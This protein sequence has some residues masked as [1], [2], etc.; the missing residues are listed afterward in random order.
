MLRK[1]EMLPSE[2]RETMS[3]RWRKLTD[4]IEPS[5]IFTGRLLLLFQ[6]H[7]YDTNTH[8]ITKILT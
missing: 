2:Y 3:P 6:T 5:P 7:K 8:T 4:P 1:P